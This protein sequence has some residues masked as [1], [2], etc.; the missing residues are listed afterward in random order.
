[1][2]TAAASRGRRQP[3]IESL[4][5]AAIEQNTKSRIDP[6]SILGVIAGPGCILLAQ[7]LEGGDIK[8]LLQRSAALIVIGAPEAPL[9]YATSNPL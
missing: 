8:S 9:M 1:V 5:V 3:R 6:A 4:I 2:I 7:W